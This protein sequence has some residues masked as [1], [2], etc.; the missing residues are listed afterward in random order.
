MTKINITRYKS[1]GKWLE[2]I[3]DESILEC[4]DNV[5]IQAQMESHYGF[6]ESENYVMSLISSNGACF[7]ERLILNK[8]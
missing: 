8:S 5:G 2:T 4:F 3:E 7:N 6:L 1:T